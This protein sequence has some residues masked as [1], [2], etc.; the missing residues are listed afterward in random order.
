MFRPAIHRVGLLLIAYI[1]FEGSSPRRGVP[2][3]TSRYRT[4]DH[5]HVSWSLPDD[6]CRHC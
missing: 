3:Y 6:I 5:P 2:M 4:F 1:F